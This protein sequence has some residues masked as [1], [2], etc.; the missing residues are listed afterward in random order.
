MGL[1]LD[2]VKRVLAFQFP[3]L[4]FLL[5]INEKEKRKEQN[6]IDCFQFPLLGFLLCI[7]MVVIHQDVPVVVFQFPLL[8]FLLCIK[9][10]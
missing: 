1:S 3:L 8:G 6:R 2:D 10:T 5:C 7:I 9:P 4:G